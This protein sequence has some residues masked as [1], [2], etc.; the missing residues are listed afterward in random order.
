MRKRMIGLML[1]L[2]SLITGG[3]AQL[4]FT[5]IQYGWRVEKDFVYGNAINYAG[6]NDTLTLDLYKPVG[7]DNTTRPVLVLVHGGVWLS[8]CKTDMAWLAIE[9]AQRGYVVACVNYRKGWHKDAGPVDP[10]VFLPNLNCLYPADSS[11][12]YRA[13]YRGVQDVK[14][15]IRWL[16]A[17][18]VEDSTCN[19]TVLVGGE[20]AGAFLAMGVGFLDRPSEKP[21]DCNALPDAPVPAANLANCYDKKCV[22][23]SITLQGNARQRPDLGSVE[24]TLNQN[25]YTASV[26]GVI[27]LYGGVPYE[28]LTQNWVEGPN[29]PAVYF[30]HQTCDGVVL[31]GQGQPFLPISAYCNLGATPWH[32]KYPI[33]FG[34]GAVAAYFATL[35]NA[36]V[37]TTDF[38]NCDAFNPAISLFD[39]VRYS[40]N[41]SYHFVNNQ[42]LRAGLIANFFSPVVSAQLSSPG[43]LVAQQ[44]PV[45]PWGIRIAPNPFAGQVKI[46]CTAPPPDEVRVQICDV[47]GKTLWQQP[48]GLQLGINT[49]SPDLPA[50]IYFLHL[51][52]T[53]WEGTW[54]LIC[55]E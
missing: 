38:D 51:A 23:Q 54:K 5:T 50:G 33:A 26:I 22:I 48:M 18:S 24:G 39:C 13:I 37:Y 43:C 17:R 6:L 21:A 9:M 29:Q 20:S 49:L 55:R 4:P 44:E 47:S 8:G 35:P 25:G 36:P 41:G 31:F 45:D 3:Y 27:S 11:E 53:A 19:Q 1:L 32:Y 30:Y 42:P 46:T 16:K 40:Q 7:D 15:A 28:A 34:N 12:I 2:L 52:G 10:G 14:G